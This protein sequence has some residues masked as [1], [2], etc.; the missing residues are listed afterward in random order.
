MLKK[1]EQGGLNHSFKEELASSPP[2]P[3]RLSS[4]N[5]RLQVWGECDTLSVLVTQGEVR[6]MKLSLPPSGESPLP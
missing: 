1:L 6:L 5:S 4:P 2:P 3:T